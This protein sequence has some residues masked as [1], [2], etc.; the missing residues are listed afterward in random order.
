M[1]FVEPLSDPSS[2]DIEIYNA[3]TE[4]M[5]SDKSPPPASSASDEDE[6]WGMVDE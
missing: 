2:F 4:R 5:A 3:K 6:F 1:P